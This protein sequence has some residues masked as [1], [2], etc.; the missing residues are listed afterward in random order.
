M[1]KKLIFMILF[2]LLVLSC[3]NHQVE[4]KQEKLVILTSFYPMYLL[5]LNIAEGIEGVEIVNLVGQAGG[6]LHGYQLTPQDMKKVEQAS[7]LV[8]NSTLHEPFVSQ[9]RQA[10]PQLKIIEAGAGITPIEDHAEQEHDQHI[11]SAFN[12]HYWVSPRLAIKEVENIA[13]GLSE[14]D[15]THAQKY[16]TNMTNYTSVLQQLYIHMRSMLQSFHGRG[17]VTYH[18]AFTYF[19]DDM[20]LVLRGTLQLEPGVNPT[21]KQLYLLENILK[22]HKNTP[23]FSEPQYPSTL[24]DNL[25]KETGAKVYSLN[26]ITNGPM[27]AK[28]Y[29]EIMTENAQTLVTALSNKQMKVG[30]TGFE[31]AIFSSQ[32]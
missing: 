32:N 17:V 31:P 5:T 3:T 10:Y 11:H 12:T 15:P 22:E 24:A 21:P 23:I 1:L 29:E 2:S 25:A 14:I 8:I 20:G 19:L 7:V 16:E 28:A 4:K 9:I 13:C 27:T 6:D 30:M 18:N 26:P